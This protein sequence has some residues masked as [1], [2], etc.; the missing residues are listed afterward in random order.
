MNYLRHDRRNNDF[1]IR[2]I[3]LVFLLLYGVYFFLGRIIAEGLYSIE[4][5]VAEFLGYYDDP[6]RPISENSLIKDLKRENDSLKVLLGRGDSVIEENQ[7]TV[8]GTTTT[9]T[10]T[11]TATT[12]KKT[13]KDIKKLNTPD[14][15]LVLGVVL[16]RPPRTPYD[17]LLIDIGEDEGL[18]PGDVVYAE[19]DYII[20][21][22]TDVF[23]ATSVVTLLSAPD[24][25]V[26]VLLG[27]TT[28]PVVAEGRGS[29]NFYIKVPKNIQITTGDQIV[30]P[31]IHNKI[32]GTAERVDS[33]EGE[34]YSYVYFKTPVNLYSLH[35]VQVK[36]TTR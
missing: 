31:A 26:D 24:Q 4:H 32:I 27:S 23:K 33:D 28:I 7:Q 1:G 10:A 11:S 3:I 22:V 15:S 16:A 21:I 6:V 2:K 13:I 5:G 14:K 36:K 17:S 9:A 34:A 8:Q 30:A 12:T 19:Q 20:G 29:G 18:M 35:Y 25:K